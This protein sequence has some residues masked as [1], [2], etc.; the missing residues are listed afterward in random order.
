MDANARSHTAAIIDDCLESEGIAR[1]S[2]PAYSPDLNSIEKLSDD[3]GRVA[4]LR[5]PPQDALI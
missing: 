5:F 2:W 3:L 4:S 1:M